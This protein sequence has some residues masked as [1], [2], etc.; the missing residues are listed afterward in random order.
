[1]NELIEVAFKAALQGGAAILNVYGSEDFDIEI[2]GDNSPLTRADRAA[3]DCITAVLS[4]TKIPVISEEDVR[5][6]TFEERENWTQCWIV[7]PLDGTKEFIKRNGEF[8]VNIA[9]V[10]NGKAECGVIY[11]P[12]TDTLYYG[13]SSIGSFRVDDASTVKINDIIRAARKLPLQDKPSGFHVVGSRSHGSAETENFVSRLRQEF[14]ETSFVAAGSSLK[15]CLVAEGKAHLYP[16]FA[17]TMEW[18]T[19][20]GQAIAEAAGCTVMVWPL[21]QPLRYNR[22]DLTNPWFLVSAPGVEVMH[23]SE[24]PAEEDVN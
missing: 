7:D 1:M 5:N 17:P 24:L 18:D 3:N 2:K 11:V 9:L 21:Q 4:G 6:H 15:F 19:A 22:R 16:R 23:L 10:V 14:G 8:T 12:A 13:G 20:A